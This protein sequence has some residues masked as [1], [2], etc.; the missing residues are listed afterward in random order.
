MRNKQKIVKLSIRKNLSG[1]EARTVLATYCDAK[2]YLFRTNDR[3]VL[4]NLNSKLHEIMLQ[5]TNE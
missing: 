4:D 1:A 5:Y 2:D 3:K